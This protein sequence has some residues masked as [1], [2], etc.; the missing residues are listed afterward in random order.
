MSRRAGRGRVIACAAGLLLALPAQAQP[1]T[2]AA[3]ANQQAA[4]QALAAAYG[5]RTQPAPR[6]V[7]GASGKLA[8]QVRSGAPFDLYCAADGAYPAQLIADGLAL[9]PVAVFAQGR[10]IWWSRDR[11]LARTP[12]ARL[13]PAAIG[14]IAIANPRH[15]PY[16]ARA[17]EALRRA[18][19]W[20]ALQSRLV[21]GENVGQAAHFAASGAAD[22]AL[23][24][25]SQLHSAQLAGGHWSEVDPALHAPLPQACV[26]IRAG[27]AAP[28]ARAFLAWLQGAQA[29]RILAGHGF[30]APGGETR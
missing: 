3:A 14:R 29:R 10:L 17:E 2:I 15:A 21:I 28:Q 25:R 26:V 27:R 16:G 11:A 20:P 6:L 9:P 24:A 30:D 13:D 8:A 1:P 18:G 4:M 19:L 23:L 22:A 7:F 5:T 12:L